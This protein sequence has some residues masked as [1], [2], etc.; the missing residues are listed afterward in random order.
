MYL[1]TNYTNTRTCSCASIEDKLAEWCLF[2]VVTIA[3]PLQATGTYQL[4]V[5]LYRSHS[6]NLVPRLFTIHGKPGYE[7]NAVR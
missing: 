1:F 3:T 6:Y 5:L 7:A 2:V 4:R